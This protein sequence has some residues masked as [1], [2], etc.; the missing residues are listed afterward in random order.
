MEKKYSKHP[1]IKIG[2]LASVG[3]I[4]DLGELFL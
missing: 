3:A 4:E 2:I 1:F